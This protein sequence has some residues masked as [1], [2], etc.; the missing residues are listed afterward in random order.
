MDMNSMFHECSAHPAKH[1]VVGDRTTDDYDDDEWAS[2]SDQYRKHDH[3]VYACDDVLSDDFEGKEALMEENQ[4]YH[5]YDDDSLLTL[6]CDSTPGCS[7]QLLPLSKTFAHRIAQGFETYYQD[8]YDD[9]DDDHA[10]QCGSA[11]DGYFCTG[12][13]TGNGHYEYCPN[14]DKYGV[15]R[16][17]GHRIDDLAP[18]C[19]CN[20][21]EY[22]R[23]SAEGLAACAGCFDDGAD[24]LAKCPTW[25]EL[26]EERWSAENERG[27]IMECLPD[28]FKELSAQTGFSMDNFYLKDL[29]CNLLDNQKGCEAADCD[30]IDN[31]PTDDNYYNYYY[32]SYDTVFIWCSASSKRHGIVGGAAPPS[33]KQRAAQKRLEQNT[34]A[35]AKACADDAASTACADA[36]TA[37]EE[38]LTALEAAVPEATF[39]AATGVSASLIAVVIAAATIAL[40]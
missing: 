24:A 19:A 8:D 34:K 31:T 30:W 35:M 33:P 9:Y 11:Q 5:Y 40:L 14:N 20:V 39:D 7:M 29:Q 21:Y 36:T 12:G 26:E 2:L 28:N 4:F 6:R 17:Y 10:E 37:M 38:S 13:V 23:L 22:G 3:L 15:M 16:G 32:V 25:K 27:G 1:G 18:V